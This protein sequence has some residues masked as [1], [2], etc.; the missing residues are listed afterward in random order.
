MRTQPI[1]KKEGKCGARQL[2]GEA[3]LV[4]AGGADG[5]DVA[6]GEVVGAHGGRM[7]QRL[8]DAIHEAGVACAQYPL[9]RL[10]WPLAHGG[11][12]GSSIR[13]NARLHSPGQCMP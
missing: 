5:G 2:A 6:A 13:K 10:H 1:K 11:A 7:Q 8:Q 12:S 4:A 9:G 3:G